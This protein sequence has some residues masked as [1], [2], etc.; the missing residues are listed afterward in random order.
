NRL[1]EE[2]R[3][4]DI[5][6]LIVH[7]PGQ[8]QRGDGAFRVLEVPGLEAEVLGAGQDATGELVGTGDARSADLQLPQRLRRQAAERAPGDRARR[9]ARGETRHRPSVLREA[10]AAREVGAGEIA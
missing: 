9:D 2:H 6:D 10:Q 8:G 7:E 5:V 1:L 4:V 3:A